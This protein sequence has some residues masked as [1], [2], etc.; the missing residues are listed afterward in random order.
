[1]VFLLTGQ[2]AGTEYD[3]IGG[4]SNVI[5]IDLNVS[6]TPGKYIDGNQGE[7]FFVFCSQKIRIVGK[8]WV[9]KKWTYFS[10]VG[11]TSFD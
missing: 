2:A 10:V 4:G 9:E 3:K 7:S 8:L 5:C 11:Q 6:H 1:M